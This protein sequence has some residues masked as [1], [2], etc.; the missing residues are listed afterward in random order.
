MLCLVRGGG[1]KA[2]DT[3]VNK[4]EARATGGLPSAEDRR[5][6]GRSDG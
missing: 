3:D 5:R 6:Q 4:A 1:V 2:G